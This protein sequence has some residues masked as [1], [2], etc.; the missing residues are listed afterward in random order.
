MRKYFNPLLATACTAAWMCVHGNIQ[1]EET[2][3]LEVLEGGHS[4]YVAGD[5]WGRVGA[6]RARDAALLR[7]TAT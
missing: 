6:G 7:L 1:T 5:L 2:A 4:S 3:V